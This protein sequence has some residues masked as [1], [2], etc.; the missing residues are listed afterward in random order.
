M[1]FE[2]KQKKI[3]YKQYPEHKNRLSRQ[4]MF[5]K[6]IAEELNKICE[7]VRVETGV[8]VSSTFII[9]L[10]LRYFFE[11]LEKFPDSKQLKI[12]VDGVFLM[13]DEE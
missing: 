8:K 11:Y 9:D 12:I 4:I 6:V 3:K 7:V 1:T 2:N 13:I 10:A 5:D